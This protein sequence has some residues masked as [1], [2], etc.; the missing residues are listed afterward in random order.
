MKT[1]GNHIDFLLFNKMNKS[2]VM[3]IEVDGTRYHVD[4]SRQAERDAMKNSI[5]AKCGIPILRFPEGKA[6]AVTLSYDDGAPSDLRFSDVITKAGLKC[7]FNLSANGKVTDEQ[8]KEYMLDRG[9]E[10]ATHG[11]RHR[12]NCMQ[13]P[14]EGIKDVFVAHADYSFDGANALR[15]EIIAEIWGATDADFIAREVASIVA[16]FDAAKD[17]VQ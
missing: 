16:Q 14:I 4:G 3:A 1:T 13:R 12:A 8:Y 11:A 2:P 9:H 15:D 10:I 6:K 7:T 17:A 5:L